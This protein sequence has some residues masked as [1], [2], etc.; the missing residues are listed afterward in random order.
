MQARQQSLSILIIYSCLGKLGIERP[1]ED[2]KKALRAWGA[3]EYHWY[4]FGIRQEVSDLVYEDMQ[5]IL[6]GRHLGQHGEGC[7]LTHM[8]G[9]YE[10]DEAT[11][12]CEFEGKEYTEYHWIRFF[13]QFGGAQ[14]HF[15]TTS[16][17]SLGQLGRD[18]HGISFDEAA[19]EP[20]LDFLM[21]DVFHMRRAGTGGQLILTSTPVEALGHA[22]ARNWKKG[23]PSNPKRLPTWMALRMSSRDN[24]GYG[25]S[26]ELFA[27]MIS[28][29]DEREI[30]QNIDGEF[31]Q[32]AGA[33]FNGENVERVFVETMPG[34]SPAR[35]RTIYLQGVD[36]AKQVDSAW[37]IVLAVRMPMSH[38][39]HNKEKCQCKPYL[40]GVDARRLKG[41]KSTEQLVDLAAEGSNAYN[42][43][44]IGA[45]CYTAIDATGFGGKMFREAIEQ[46]VLNL[47]NV[48]FGGTSQ[49]K[50]KLLGN[51]RTV[52]DEGRL[53]L[54]L[55]GFWTEV[56]DQVMNYVLEDRAVEQDAVMA[57][58]CAV[59]LLDI[60]PAEGTDSTPLD[61]SVAA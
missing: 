18:M 49:K 37:A 28:D 24:V 23:D 14:V 33:Y 11:P 6:E 52:I 45:I 59:S 26:E 31:L 50:K 47:H 25:L 32:A 43:P 4:H 12:I 44:K 55:D 56:F 10:D 16:Q 20:K 53:I 2:D 40:V 29:M 41:Q 38:A 17:K 7:P 15:R 3:K 27:L 51:L 58:V 39:K 8:G 54:P 48:E 30:A 57:L 5:R 36:P 60:A 9:D 19:L 42:V 61:N 34:H 13:P 22:F 21:K 1:D 35:K 46:Y